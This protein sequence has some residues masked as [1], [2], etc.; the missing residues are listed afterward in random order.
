MSRKKI[1]STETTFFP[2]GTEVKT[3]V[4]DNEELFV[5]LFINQPNISYGFPNHQ[6]ILQM[7]IIMDYNN[8][9]VLNPRK[10]QIIGNIIGLCLSSID[11][12]LKQLID[13]NL[14]IR[15]YPGEYM[16]NPYIFSKADSK[17]TAKLRETYDNELKKRLNMRESNEQIW[18]NHRWA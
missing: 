14:A 5:K 12:L 17:K 18:Y 6:F 16:I 1:I 7:T 13:K 3:N 11:K 9:V 15:L 8:I 2:Y 10:K 4:I